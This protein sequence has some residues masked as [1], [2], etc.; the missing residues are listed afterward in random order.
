MKGTISGVVVLLST[1]MIAAGPA[2]AMWNVDVPHTGIEFTVRHFFTP[3]T[4]RFDD[5]EIELEFDRENPANS[6]V[7]VRIDV[8]SVNT[9]NERRDTHLRSGDFFDADRYPY[10]TFEAEHVWMTDEGELVARGPLTIKAETRQID[11]PIRIL[12]VLDVPEEMREMLGGVTE[13]A[14]FQATLEID[15]GDYGVGAG[16]WATAMVVGHEVAISIAV[17][18]NR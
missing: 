13:I 10:I 3:V 7:T 8:A 15:R 2:P 5:Y 1:V 17:E 16:S 12:G 9:G 14:S 11:L 6:T 4:G 18:A